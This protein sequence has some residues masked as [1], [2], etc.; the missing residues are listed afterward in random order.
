MLDQLIEL[1]RLMGFQRLSIPRQCLIDERHR[2]PGVGL[3]SDAQF[4]VGRVRSFQARGSQTDWDD[5]ILPCP[6]VS[7]D[8]QVMKADCVDVA[9]IVMDVR[10]PRCYEVITGGRLA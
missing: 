8:V 5:V 7:R 2:A 3:V 10:P 1:D 9:S 6:G 4:I